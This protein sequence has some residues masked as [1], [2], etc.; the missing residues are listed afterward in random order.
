MSKIKCDRIWMCFY[1]SKLRLLPSMKLAVSRTRNLKLNWISTGILHRKSR[2]QHARKHWSW[3]FFTSRIIWYHSR[4]SPC[5]YSREINSNHWVLSENKL[6]NRWNARTVGRVLPH[7]H[8]L[9]Y[10]HEAYARRGAFD[11]NQDHHFRKQ[12]F[13]LILSTL[14]PGHFHDWL[15]F[16]RRINNKYI[17]SVRSSTVYM[18]TRSCWEPASKFA[19][20]SAPVCACV[21]AN[22]PLPSSL[23]TPSHQDRSYVD[24]LSYILLAHALLFCQI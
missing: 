4:I 8:G 10:L 14:F 11:I 1:S 19:P 6:K 3:I 12:S 21:C 18:S 22:L 24:S 7:G 23:L 5:K 15:A 2:I 13:L 17:T 9:C 20:C 16:D